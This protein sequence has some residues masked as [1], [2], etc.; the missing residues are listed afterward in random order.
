MNTSTTTTNNYHIN[1]DA[2]WVC[3][4]TL[5]NKQLVFDTAGFQS[6]QVSRDSESDCLDCILTESVVVCDW[7]VVC[8]INKAKAGEATWRNLIFGR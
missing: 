6:E 7:A 3:T 4:W 2:Y 1:I 5:R 8:E